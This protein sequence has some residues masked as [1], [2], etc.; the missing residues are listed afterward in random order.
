MR[1]PSAPARFIAIA[2]VIVAVLAA[3]TAGTSKVWFS[4]LNPPGAEQRDLQ[5]MLALGSRATPLSTKEAF[6]LFERLGNGSSRGA[7]VAL[8]NQDRKHGL[9]EEFVKRLEELLIEHRGEHREAAIVLGRMAEY[10]SFDEPVERAFREAINPVSGGTR[11]QPIQVLGRIGAHRPLR[12]QT[13]RALLEVADTQPAAARTALAALR[14]TAERQG[15]PAWA[16]ER[17]ENIASERRGAIR[18]DA[19]AVMAAAGANER[20]LAALNEAGTAGVHR[21]AIALTLAGDDLAELI[22]KLED[23]GLDAEVRAE[24]LMQFV[25]RRDQSTLVGGALTYAFGSDEPALRRV[26]FA[27]YPE[28]GRHHV[29]HIAVDWA[30]VTATAFDAEDA[31]IRARAASAFRFIPLGD[32]EAR[33]GFV[34]AML[35]GSAR[36]QRTALTA[37]GSVGHLSDALRVAIRALQGSPDPDVARLARLREARATPASRTAR[38]ASWFAGTVFWGLLALPAVIAVGFETLFVAR[39]LQGLA[40]GA[41]RIAPLAISVVWFALS[42]SL[43]VALFFAVLGFGQGGVKLGIWVYSALLGVSLAFAGVGWLLSLALQVRS[44]RAA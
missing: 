33:D 1:N 26:A 38:L 19:I 31:T 23:D 36:Q 5:D 3:V 16:L 42:V 40:E 10:R 43:G 12:Q 14:M 11:T 28:W 13:L 34:R 27:T 37:L 25:K 24:A 29:S 39:F 22:R 8:I 41:R 21:E 2:L 44:R 17:V 7:D 6:D 35:G 32:L 9:P 30:R 18:S 20:A 4:W 15:L